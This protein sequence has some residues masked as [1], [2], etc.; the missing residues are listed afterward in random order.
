MAKYTRGEF[1]GFGAAL[2]GAF[3]LGRIGAGHVEPSV[4]A[5]P[6]TAGGEP[7]LVVVNARVLTSDTALPRAEAFASRNGRFVAVGSSADVRNL[8]TARTSVI[9]AQTMT[10]VP[11]FIDAHC[12]PSG[13]EEL[14]GVNT[15]LRTVR[16]IQSAIRRKAESS[17]PEIWITGFMF[18]DTK[19]DRPLTRKDLDEATT[20]HPVSVAHRGGHTNFYNSKA[21]ELAGI[22]AQTP[23]PSDGRFF[24][25]NGELNGRVAEN[26]RDVF[27]RIGKHESVTPEQRRDRARNGMKHMS[28]LFNACGLTSVHNAGT[29]QDHI[30]AYEDCRKNGELTHRAYMMIRSPQAFT[31]LKAAN[32]YTGFGDEWIRVGGVKFVADGSASERTMRM[33]TPYV[34]TS[35]YG[36]LTMTQDQLDEA[37]DDAHSH[38]FQVGVHAN[39]DVT[40]DM[41]LKAY[42]RALQKWPDP[43]RRHRIEHCTLVNP[44]LI[45]RIKANGVIP[46]PFW[47]YVYYH[48]EKWKEYGDS[49]IAWMFAHRSFL[50]A[51]IRVPGASDYTPGPFEPLMALQSMVTRKD[52]RGRVWGPNQK[53]TIDEAL[54]IATINGAYASSEENLKGSITAGKL[55]DFVVLEKDPHDVDPDQI[56][57]VKVNR[58]VVGGKTVYGG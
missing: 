21:F 23:D 45:R 9:D 47:T 38:G 54:T 50:D 39:G 4:S 41:V 37:I 26:A 51:G 24:K 20:E 25:T 17:S 29:S 33:S 1:L 53:V 46:T 31:G 13:V 6:S 32:I 58:T 14:Y 18:D 16:E 42:E 52:Y 34:G 43:N 44:D 12:H 49:K 11:G 8:A 19:L 22:T 2:A 3:S 55:A 56:M 28:Q 48:G 5:Q 10:V 40:I 36:I 15:N 7:D 57:N 30:L 35:D 27:D